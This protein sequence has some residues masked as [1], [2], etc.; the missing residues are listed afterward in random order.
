MTDAGIAAK[1]G[2]T[3]KGWFGAP[4]REGTGS[5]D[6]K[7]IAEI[8]RDRLGAGRWYGQMVAVS[9]ELAWGLRVAGQ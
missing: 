3:W 4:D 7:A 5:L 8:A 9:Y 6:H 2:K 1:T